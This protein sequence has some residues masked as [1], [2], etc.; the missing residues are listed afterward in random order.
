[1]RGLTDR[2]R[3]ELLRSFRDREEVQDEEAVESLLAR[4]LLSATD[5]GAWWYY[6]PTTDAQLALRLDAAVRASAGMVT[7]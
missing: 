7:T 2:E 3:S 5:E 4:G 1:V 6:E